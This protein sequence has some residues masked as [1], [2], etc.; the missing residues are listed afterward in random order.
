[1]CGCCEMKNAYR[2]FGAQGST[3]HAKALRVK[4]KKK[5]PNQSAEQTKQ[6]AHTKKNEPSAKEKRETM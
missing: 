1:M 4:Q 6:Q 2:H 5:H 3:R